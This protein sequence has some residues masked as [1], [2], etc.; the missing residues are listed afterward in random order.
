MNNSKSSGIGCGLLI[1]IGVL[2]YVGQFLFTNPLGW[3]LMVVGIAIAIASS[4]SRKKTKQLK[5]IES[6]ENSAQV[7]DDMVAGKEPSLDV[8][9]SLQK[10]EKLIYSMPTVALT[11][12]Q[13]TGSSYSG[14][15][16]GVSFPIVGGIRG[17]VGGQSGEITKNPEQLM[18][19]D[20]GRVMFTDQRI[21][22][23]GAKLVRDWDL[24]KAIEV[25]PGPNG[26][27]VKIAVSNRERTSGLQALTG[28][29]FGP[30]FAAAY[31]FTLHSQ[32]AAEAKKWANELSERMRKGAAS[33][34]AKLPQQAIET[35]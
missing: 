20:Q 17:N 13:S 5:L 27:N 28:Y 8:G 32:G 6:L 22:F 18:I 3:V 11:E 24:D 21:I 35:K 23:S 10:G 34:R 15:S 25:A 14:S 19:V 2:F 33:E 31:V 4:I 1:I 26:F 30:G 12:Y 29:E 9:F 7:L 16:A